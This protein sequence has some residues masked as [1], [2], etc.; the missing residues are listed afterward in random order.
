MSSQNIDVQ[1][2]AVK[3]LPQLQITDSG[4]A[5]I[6]MQKLLRQL[7]FSLSVDGSYGDTTKKR[8][9]EFQR[10]NGLTSDGVVGTSTW[11]ELIRQFNPPSVS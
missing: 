6:L 2:L 3:A 10:N 8:V 7:G 11:H 1:A 5:V 9:T 4:D